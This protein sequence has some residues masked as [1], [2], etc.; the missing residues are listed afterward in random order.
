[1][2]EHTS[3]GTWFAVLATGALIVWLDSRTDRVGNAGTG[4]R[5]FS[6]FGFDSNPSTAPSAP[7]A[8][9][10]AAPAGNPAP[11]PQRPTQAPSVEAAP[12]AYSPG[13]N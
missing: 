6:L 5:Q 1:M 11:A 13:Q 2:F 10:G 3:N 4:R 12:P 9:S 8:T 7:A